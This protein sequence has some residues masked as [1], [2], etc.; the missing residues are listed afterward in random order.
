MTRQTG[1]SHFSVVLGSARLV[2]TLPRRPAVRP[3]FVMVSSPGT[4]T[5]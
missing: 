3:A 2:M 5:V 4:G 1:D